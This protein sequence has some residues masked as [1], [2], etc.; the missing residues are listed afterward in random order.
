MNDEV[1]L[2]G[3]RRSVDEGRLQWQVH[4]LERLLERGLSRQQ[5]ERAIMNGEVIETYPQD[6]PFPSC[7]M[8]HSQPE[9]LHVVVAFDPGARICHI[10]TAYAPD[11]EHFEP[12]FRTRRK[13]R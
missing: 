9:P 5:V 12:D 7:L 13:P 3:L 10:I 2:D 11:T 4:A 8:L 6:R 1:D